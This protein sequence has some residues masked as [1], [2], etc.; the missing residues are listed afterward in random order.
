MTLIILFFLAC[1]DSP[2]QT[3]STTTST[4]V[5]ATTAISSTTWT[6]DETWTMGELAGPCLEDGSD[7]IGG[8]E[9]AH[10]DKFST[11][12]GN[13]ASGVLPTAILDPKEEG[14]ECMLFK[15][16]YPFCDPG[17]EAGF[18][19]DDF[20]E[21]IP[22]PTNQSLGSVAVHGLLASLTLE[23]DGSN[24]Y[25]DTAVPFPMFYAGDLISIEAAGDE[26]EGFTLRSIGVDF[27]EFDSVDWV[28][29]E[30]EDLHISW[31]SSP[32]A[33]RVVFDL[34]V[35]QHGN[36]PVSMI[37]DTPDDGELTIESNLLDTLMLYGV[38]GFATATARRQVAD[39]VHLDAGCVDL[40][41]LHHVN[42]NLLVKGHTACTSDEDCPKGE[43]CE[44]AINTCVDD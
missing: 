1:G 12:T 25:W 41:A 7:R 24:Y 6:T 42:G 29:V 26:I 33:N 10:W 22:Y 36:S 19:C 9:I 38:S 8:F 17:C 15:K 2:E 40:L 39:S 13:V 30:G 34:N 14:S 3:T 21:C 31:I 5:T 43:H 44:V 32:N 16:D 18:V 23:P 35:D 27:L 37:C 4:T 11:V 20:G 28:I